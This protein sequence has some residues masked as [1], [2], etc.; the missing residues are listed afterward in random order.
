MGNMVVLGVATG[1]LAFAAWAV[2]GGSIVSDGMA[3]TDTSTA[4]RE[5]VKKFPRIQRFAEGGGR[6]HR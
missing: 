1:G 4:R 6:S 3:I 2:A 5:L